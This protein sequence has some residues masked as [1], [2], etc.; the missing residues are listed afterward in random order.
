MSKLL[1]DIKDKS[2]RFVIPTLGKCFKSR[3]G[4]KDKV[5]L[6]VL[7]K[8]YIETDDIETCYY[9]TVFLNSHKNN[10]FVP[11]GDIDKILSSNGSILYRQRVY[12]KSF[13]TLLKVLKELNASIVIPDDF[14]VTT[15]TLVN[16][17]EELPY[18]ERYAKKLGLDVDT[19]LTHV[20]K[21]LIYDSCKEFDMCERVN[22]SES[23][24]NVPR[25]YLNRAPLLCGSY[26]IIR[27]TSSV[28]R[29]DSDLSPNLYSG[30]KTKGIL[31]YGYTDSNV[32]FDR[33]RGV[34]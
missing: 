28:I 33:K 18:L 3:I 1:N 8:G 7:N 25:G 13:T 24:Y 21:I 15:N 27:H 23:V 11:V 30:E 9:V 5:L 16:V 12:F 20:C 31:P 34:I 2:F 6:L 26:S 19:W 17:V 22:L 4:K 32:N 10:I 29:V 14:H